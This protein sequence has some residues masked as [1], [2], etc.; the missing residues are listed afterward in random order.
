[1]NVEENFNFKCIRCGNCCN[2]PNTIVNL[3]YSDLLRI[4]EGLD[5]DLNEL[6]EIV[7]FY[8]FNEYL[9]ENA[10]K[11][12]V[13][14][15]IKTERGNSYIGLLKDKIGKCIF[16]DSINKKC[17]IYR[18]RPNFCQ[19]FPFTF[20]SREKSKE[21]DLLITNKGK[22]YCRGLTED[23]PLIN[24]AKWLKLG[25][26]VLKDLED[27]VKLI[28]EWELLIKKKEI[29]PSAKE[30]LRLIIEFGKRKEIQKK[31]SN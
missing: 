30:Y 24:R 17:K 1:M 14:P 16:Y 7:G 6:L 22:E 23:A 9:D 21:L 31:S 11:R 4:K 2:D 5:L 10:K 12:L 27:N 13:T 15:P 19:T 8:I 28:R 20:Q 18:L 29:K 3:S 26:R 25:N